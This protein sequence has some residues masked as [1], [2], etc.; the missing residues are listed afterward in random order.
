MEVE[1]LSVSSSESAERERLEEE[2]DLC[3]EGSFLKSLE[4]FS[5]WLSLFSASSE[6]ERRE[7]VSFSL[8]LGS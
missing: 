2:L 1:C 8:P 4:R 5:A 6:V 7:G 3:G